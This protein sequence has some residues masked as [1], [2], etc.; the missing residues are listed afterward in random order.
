MR[1]P[2][3]RSQVVVLACCVLL[4]FLLPPHACSAAKGS[5]EVVTKAPKTTKTTKAPKVRRGGA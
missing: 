4:G 2:T 3:M 1:A 5:K